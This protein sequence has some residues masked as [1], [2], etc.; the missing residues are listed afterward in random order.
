MKRM[1]RQVGDKS[2]KPKPHLHQEVTMID[3]EDEFRLTD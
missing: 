2:G 1:S 3:D